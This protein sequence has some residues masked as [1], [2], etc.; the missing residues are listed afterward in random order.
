MGKDNH[1]GE[2]VHDLGWVSNIRAIGSPNQKWIEWYFSSRSRT[3]TIISAL[4][5]KFPTTHDLLAV[6]PDI[7][8]ATH[9]VDVCL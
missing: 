4:Y 6:E 9:T 8:I 7:E 1:A 5:Q 2:C 3:S